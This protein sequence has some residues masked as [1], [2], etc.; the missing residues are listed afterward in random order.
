MFYSVLLLADPTRSSQLRHVTVR[1]AA[2]FAEREE[3]CAGAELAVEQHLHEHDTVAVVLVETWC[4]AE[5]ARWR[6]RALEVHDLTAL[7]ELD[8][9]TAMLSRLA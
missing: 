2:S 3:A 6:S 5:G 9:L 7:R 4:A 8:A 1:N